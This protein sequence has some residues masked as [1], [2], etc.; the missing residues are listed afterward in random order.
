M[1]HE[2]RMTDR[3]IYMG[4][5]PWH[6]KGIAFDAIGSTVAEAFAKA[7]LNWTVRREQLML[8]DGRLVDR[9]AVIRNSDNRVL[10]TVGTDWRAIQHVEK[11]PAVLDPFLAAGEA[12]IETAGALFDGG[13]VWVLLKISRPD[14]VIV[15][16]AGDTVAKYVLAAVGYDGTLSFTFGIT[17]IR[18]VCNNTLSAAFGHGQKTHVRIRHTAGGNEAVDALAETINAVDAQ[19]E[20]AAEVFRALAGVE[21]K[22]AA[23]LRAYVDAVF[24]APKKAPKSLTDATPAPEVSGDD[25]FAALLARPALISTPAP[26]VLAGANPFTA[27]PSE[28]E[29]EDGRRIF[30]KILHNFEEGIGADLPGVKGTAWGAYNAVTQYNTWERGRSVDSRLNNVWLSQSGPVARALPAAVSSFLSA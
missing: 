15:P 17:P 23:Q 6:D 5:K 28:D 18:V 3:M 9:F 22:S 14:A 13:R 24:P 8:A 7:G 12:T 2:I 30:D 26:M 20:K 11:F 1:A 19:I 27:Q 16:Q 4:A 25:S 10:G 21:I 29:Q